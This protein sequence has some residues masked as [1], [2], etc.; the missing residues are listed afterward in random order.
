MS[1]YKVLYEKFP[2]VNA[3]ISSLESRKNNYIMRDKHSSKTGSSEFTG[4]RSYEEAVKISS[5]GYDEAAKLLKKDIAQKRKIQSKFAS[6]VNHPTPHNAVVGYIPNV[7]NAIRNIPE[8]MITKEKLPVKRKTLNIIYSEHGNCDKSTNYFIESGA[9]ILSAVELI[10][11]SG[12]QVQIDLGFM[13]SASGNEI[14]FPTV[15]IKNYDERYSY[16]KVSFPLAHPSMFRR[17]GFRWLETT[18]QITQ[19]TFNLGY[20]HAPSTHTMMDSLTLPKNTYYVDTEWVHNHNCSVEEILKKL[21]V[22]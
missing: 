8:S 15:K 9:A 20:G 10:E 3:L 14:S 1:E 11:K 6:M 4:S 13:T 12:I 21:E 7:P 18:P 22:I 16:Q 2:S 5:I 17:I 19:E